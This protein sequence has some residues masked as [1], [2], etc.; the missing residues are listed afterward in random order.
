MAILEEQFAEVEVIVD[1]QPAPEY[2][3]DDDTEVDTPKS[4]TRYIEV[5]PGGE[6]SFSI[7]LQPHF[8]W[9]GASCIVARP[10]IDGKKHTGI[11]LDKS[12]GH[13]TGNITGEWA[14]TGDS[15]TQYKF[16]F[17]NIETR[18]CSKAGIPQ[19]AY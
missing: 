16:T 2:D 14:G 10:K 5:V 19:A 4:V 9:K 8:R 11:I 18:K 1:G 15:A 12:R 7:K 3:N 13:Y 6:F 17:A